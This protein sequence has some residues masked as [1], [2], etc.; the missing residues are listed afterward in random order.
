MPPSARAGIL[1]KDRLALERMRT[2]DAVL[3]DKTG[4]L[5][6]G[7]H[8]VTDVAAAAGHDVDEVLADRV[9]HDD[10]EDGHRLG[11]VGPAEPAGR[12]GRRRRGSGH[13][14]QR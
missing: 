12:V 3:F 11:R 7:D 8:V 2:V 10:Q 6:R 9:V 5:T 1:V 13:G 4:T 14:A